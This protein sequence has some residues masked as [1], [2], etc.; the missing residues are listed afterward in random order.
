M[1]K[2]GE[3]Y[4][5]GVVRVSLTNGFEYIEYTKRV[6]VQGLREEKGD[7]FINTMSI[8]ISLGG[9]Q[10]LPG[11]IRVPHRTSLFSFRIRV[12][13]F[14]A[15]IKQIC[16]FHN[17]ARCNAGQHVNKGGNQHCFIFAFSSCLSNVINVRIYSSAL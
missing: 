11:L 1:R 16:T 4:R 12:V 2:I 8:P 15:F 7:R 13:E 10:Q 5:A 14:L 6:L 17:V 9:E 3:Q